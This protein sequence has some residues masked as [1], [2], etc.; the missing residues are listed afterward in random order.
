MK[1][2]IVTTVVIL[3]LL[4]SALPALATSFDPGINYGIYTGL[5]TK[6]VR[7]GIMTIVRVLLG[8]LGIIAIIGIIAGGFIM[9]TSGGNAE[10]NETGRKAITAG[11]I[12]LIII[13]TAYAIAAFV[14]SQLITATG[15]G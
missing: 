1:K 4:L 6:D 12:G 5:G 8:F 10:K 7:E 11:V 2:I 13:F 15:A 14:I 3:S 9:M